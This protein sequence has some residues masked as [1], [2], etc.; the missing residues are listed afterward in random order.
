MVLPSPIFLLRGAIPQGSNF[1]E[2]LAFSKD[3]P[4]KKNAGLITQLKLGNA[5][6]NSETQIY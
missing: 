6:Q 4:H 1:L 2:R 3:L 5:P